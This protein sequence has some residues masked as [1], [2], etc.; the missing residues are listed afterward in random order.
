VATLAGSG[1]LDAG[2]DV[3]EPFARE[4]LEIPAGWDG[5]AEIDLDRAQTVTWTWTSSADLP[6][7]AHLACPVGSSTPHTSQGQAASRGGA[8]NMTAPAHG[9]QLTLQWFN[10]PITTVVDLTLTG[11]G[12]LGRIRTEAQ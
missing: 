3:E 9:C 2:N 10:A 11:E 1:C 8:G 4:S 5:F 6:F 12:H 7:N